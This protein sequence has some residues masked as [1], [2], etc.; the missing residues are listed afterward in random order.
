MK[1]NI[2][3]KPDKILIYATTIYQQE[4]VTCAMLEDVAGRSLNPR[5]L[6][7]NLTLWTTRLTIATMNT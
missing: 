3:E 6:S 2:R 1:D 7:R 5:R 4:N